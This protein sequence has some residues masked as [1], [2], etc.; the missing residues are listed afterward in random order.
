MFSSGFG[1]SLGA[2]GDLAV[3][4]QAGIPFRGSKSI[5]NPSGLMRSGYVSLIRPPLLFQT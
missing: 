2:T 4:Q 1:W 5:Q 3:F